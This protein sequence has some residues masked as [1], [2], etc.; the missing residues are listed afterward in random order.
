MGGGVY[1]SGIAGLSF[2]KKHIQ[3]LQGKKIIVFFDGASP[4][5]EEA[6]RQTVEHNMTGDLRDIPCF[7]CR[8]AWDLDG[9]SFT[10][11]N[12]C[13]LLIKSVGKKKPEDCAVWEKALLE[14]GD[15]KCD[16]TSKA[17]IEP[18]IEEIYR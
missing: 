5:D 16:W 15:Q 8:G 3:T 1:A 18:I 2:L 12:L 7:Y 9:M 11:R 10:D 13:K 14:A 17:L 4:Y 6:F